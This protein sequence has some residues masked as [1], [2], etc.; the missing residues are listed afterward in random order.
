MALLTPY[1]AGLVE[2][3]RADASQ[4]LPAL[5]RLRVPLPLAIM[6]IAATIAIPVIAVWPKAKRRPR[7]ASEPPS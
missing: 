3:N 6:W 1:Y 2:R 7:S 4:F 5:A